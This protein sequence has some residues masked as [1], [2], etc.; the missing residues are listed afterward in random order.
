MY[1][2]TDRVENSTIQGLIALFE[3]INCE[4]LQRSGPKTA[5]QPLGREVYPCG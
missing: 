1:L 5:K 3:Q 4:S 2:P